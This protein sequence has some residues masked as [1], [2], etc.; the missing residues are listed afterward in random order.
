MKKL[1]MIG[2]LMGFSLSL[3]GCSGSENA[4]KD[5]Q[6]CTTM[7]VFQKSAGK[8]DQI[9]L[10]PPTASSPRVLSK[11]STGKG[12]QTKLV[13]I[14]CSPPLNIMDIVDASR[15]EVE[16]L[17]GPPQL[18]IPIPDVARDIKAMVQYRLK[19][20][21]ELRGIPLWD[22]TYSHGDIVYYQ[23]GGIQ[24][25]YENDNAGA[26]RLIPENLPMNPETIATFLG[27]GDQLGSP[28]PQ[29]DYNTSIYWERT[30]EHPSV[31]VYSH[32]KTP[33][34]VSS[35]MILSS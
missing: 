20:P 23:D 35:I 1:L 6:K 15:E 17:L 7:I 26:I 27:L 34:V 29:D 33:D 5:Y 18:D 19:S 10:V 4:P 28:A 2:L 22:V 13:P 30:A 24:V 14:T 21:R 25:Q 16:S 11:I 32:R 12:Y 3:G 8:D 9:K 31:S